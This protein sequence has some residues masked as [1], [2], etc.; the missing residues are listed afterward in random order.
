M[1]VLE[2]IERVLEVEERLEDSI[3]IE[4]YSINTIPVISVKLV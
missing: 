1:V 3:I 2:N 4:P